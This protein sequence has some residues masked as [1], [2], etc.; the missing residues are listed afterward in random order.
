MEC[1]QRAK[2]PS[3]CRGVAT[4]KADTVP[5]F[6]EHTVG[7]QRQDAMNKYTISMMNVMEEKVLDVLAQVN[8]S[9]SVHR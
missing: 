8:Q 4:N 3:G 2:K 1:T 6:L 7:V 5:A 9:T